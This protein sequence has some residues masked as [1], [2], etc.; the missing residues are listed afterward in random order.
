MSPTDVICGNCNYQGEYPGNYYKDIKDGIEKC[1][2][3]GSSEK[4]FINSPLVEMALGLNTT[5]E[6]K[7]EQK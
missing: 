6:G 5:L 4:L 3:C 7:V 1:P 2:E